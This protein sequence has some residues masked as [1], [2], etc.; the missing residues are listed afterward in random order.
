MLPRP[1]ARRCC[2]R[3]GKQ[4][5][6]RW[7]QAL[8]AIQDEASGEALFE[9]L[10]KPVAGM[11]QANIAG[12]TQRLDMLRSLGAD[13]LSLT[14]LPIANRRSARGMATQKVQTL[15]LLREPRRTARSVAGCACSISS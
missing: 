8:S 6:Q 4:C 12:V 7:V 2:K 11:S 5:V 14:A 10:R 3:A 13:K 15:A 9:W 1:F